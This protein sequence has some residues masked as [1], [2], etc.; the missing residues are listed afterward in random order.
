M[1]VEHEKFL[2]KQ[3][4]AKMSAQMRAIQKGTTSPHELSPPPESDLNHDQ[5]IKQELEDYTFSLPT[6]QNSFGPPSTTFQ[7]PSIA[8]YSEVSTPATMSLGLDALTAHPDMT[9]HPAAM[10]CDLQCQ[11]VVRSQASTQPTTRPLAATPSSSANLLYL[12]LISTIYSQLMHPLRM[13]F[14]SLKTGSSLPA[15]MT[16]TPMALP[17][18]RWLIS[19]PVSLLP[20]PTRRTSTQSQQ[21]SPV[22]TRSPP[23]TTPSQAPILRLRLLR[24][25]LLS[26]PSLARPLRAATE[27]AMRLKTGSLKSEN[28]ALDGMVRRVARCDR[29]A[30]LKGGVRSKSRAGTKAGRRKCTSMRSQRDRGR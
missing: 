27:R 8:T 17:L 9:Q 11:S 5:F 20:P 25:L 16:S 21:T 14:I 2:L 3:Q 13:I 1:T 23:T 18:I 28:G 29:T 24:R 6:P 12:T 15:S 10:L 4:V 30:G 19:T 22:T 26:S 7:S